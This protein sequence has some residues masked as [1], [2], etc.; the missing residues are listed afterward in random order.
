MTE[1]IEMNHVAVEIQENGQNEPNDESTRHP[2]L[3]TCYTGQI[4][5][6]STTIAAA[7]TVPLSQSYSTTPQTMSTSVPTSTTT[8]LMTT[9][10]CPNATWNNT[11][12]VVGGGY[13][14]VNYGSITDIFV[15]ANRNVYASSYAN[16]A[17]MKFFVG[18]INPILV[19]NSMPYMPMAI[20]VDAAGTIYSCEI[21][22]GLNGST[23]GRVQQ[24]VAGNTTGTTLLGGTGCN[25]TLTSLCGCGGINVDK[26]G[27]LY[28]SDTYNNRVVLFNVSSKVVN[29]VF[30]TNAVF[31]S[32]PNQLTK[33]WSISVDANN[34]VYVFDNF[35]Q[36]QY[37]TSYGPSRVVRFNAG[38]VIGTTVVPIVNNGYTMG[39]DQ[40]GQI[41]TTQFTGNG[42]SPAVYSQISKWSSIGTTFTVAINGITT[43]PNNPLSHFYGVRFDSDG[44]YYHRIRGGAMGSS[45]MHMKKNIPFA[46]LL[47]AIRYYS[48]F[49]AVLNER[50]DLRMALLLNK[51][52]CVFMD[53]HFNRV[54]QK[55]NINQPLT[56]NNK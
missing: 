42:Y 46:M 29:Y 23:Q 33:P 21:R 30:G 38:A 9:R 11:Y 8:A 50:E 12:T 2:K 45:Y 35:I 28:V 3:Y 39:V 15:D 52:L 1:A 19:G 34:N 16:M 26:Q 32:S 54:L 4:S 51:Y 44:R 6:Y 49:K 14:A 56:S 7:S 20:Y 24:Y 18:N 37:A 22:N 55:F 27:Q 17:I 43:L 53:K 41:Y 47:R 40:F 31:G 5:A 10:I 48:T 13:S 25:N 36:S